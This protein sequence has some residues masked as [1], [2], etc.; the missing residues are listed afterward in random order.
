V[1]Q[2]DTPEE[3][4]L[5]LRN[6]CEKPSTGW[7]RHSIPTTSIAKSQ[8]QRSACACLAP[9]LASSVSDQGLEFKPCLSN[10]AHITLPAPQASVVMNPV[11]LVVSTLLPWCSHTFKFLFVCFCY[12][13]NKV[14]RQDVYGLAEV[15]KSNQRIEHLYY[16]LT[17]LQQ[18]GN[19]LHIYLLT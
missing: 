9:L 17:Y 15:Q 14:L 6:T 12:E 18:A 11:C 5:V 1:Y 19:S 16:Y 4:L 7:T 2:K 8:E 3:L 10:I 13:D